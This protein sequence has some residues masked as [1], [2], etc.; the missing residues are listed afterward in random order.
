MHTGEGG[1]AEETGTAGGW[2]QSRRITLALSGD[3]MTGRGIDQVLPQPCDPQLHEGY[4]ASARDY[5]ALAEAANGQIDQPVE[6]GYVWG[7]V[8]AARDQLEPDA[9]IVN[10]ETAVTRSDDHAPKGINYRMSPE[11]AVCL[12]AAGMDCCTLANNHI[13]DW[14]VAGLTDTLETLSALG[15]KVAGA[16]VD[17]AAAARPAIIE[18][19][20]GRVLVFAFGS[21]SSGVP[22]DW[23]ATAERPG[24]NLLADLTEETA[25]KIAVHVGAARE[26]GDIVVASIHW[27]GNWGYAISLQKRR[28]A[29][30]LI[31][32]GAADIVHGHS[33]HHA[34]GI[35]VY[36][37]KP[38]LYGCGD[39]LNDYEGIR[40]YEAYRDDL[41]LLYAATFE[42]GT[43][44]LEALRML[45][46]RIKRFSLVR[47]SPEEAE[48]LTTVLARESAPLGVAIERD[49]NE[50]IA[51]RLS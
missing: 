20:T 21:P 12:S 44:A 36:R 42:A 10:L 48:W 24:V 18:C 31:D 47:A 32:A 35:E 16:G 11:N 2:R 30:W 13:L 8:L 41:V 46:F 43:G 26:T 45:P 50:I 33:S 49:G 28:F 15:L 25:E 5:V 14:G 23:T 27:G 29:Q 17:A 1:M 7:D 39:F 22:F 19:A 37:G 34:K 51:A 9:W 38:I 3:V 6:P 40:G 4:V